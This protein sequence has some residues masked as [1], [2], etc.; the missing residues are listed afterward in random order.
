[1][2]DGQYF[3]LWAEFTR[4]PCAGT[5]APDGGPEKRRDAGVDEGLFVGDELADEY[6]EAGENA[7]LPVM[8][9]LSRKD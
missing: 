3:A 2:R 6:S 8:T 4:R 5:G 1:M 7:K 9:A